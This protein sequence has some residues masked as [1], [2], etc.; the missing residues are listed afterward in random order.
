MKSNSITVTVTAAEPLSKTQLET[1]KAAVKKKYEVTDVMIEAIV[2]QTVLGGVKLV[3]DSIEYDGTVQ[4]KLA[5]V[6]SQLLNH[7]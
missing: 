4:G 5:Q 3:I 7:I 6:R 1:I 2:D